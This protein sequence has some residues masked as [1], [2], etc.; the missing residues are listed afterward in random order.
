MHSRMSVH[1]GLL[2]RC[3]PIF[4]SD[5]IFTISQHKA[6]LVCC[7]PK[8]AR[9]VRDLLVE[10]RLAHLHMPGKLQHMHTAQH[11]WP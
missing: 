11:C 1:S 9:L 6:V 2:M 7:L 8:D 4:H 10:I 5:R 3:Q